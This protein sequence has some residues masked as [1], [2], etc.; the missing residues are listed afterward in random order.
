MILEKVQD[1]F[2][3]ATFLLFAPL[4]PEVATAG[5]TL[6]NVGEISGAFTLI[7]QFLS[8]ILLI[9]RLRKNDNSKKS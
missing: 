2:I 9:K 1:C 8:A 6:I 5:S 3:G 7:I 4:I